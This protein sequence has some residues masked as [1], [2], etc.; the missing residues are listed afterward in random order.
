LFV[1]VPGI[2]SKWENNIGSSFQVCKQ[3]QSVDFKC[4]V[5]WQMQQMSPNPVI[6]KPKPHR[7]RRQNLDAG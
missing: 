4:V 7:Y 3:Q 6:P 5:A 1:K 2:N